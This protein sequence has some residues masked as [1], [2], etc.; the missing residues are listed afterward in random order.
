[1][2]NDLTTSAVILAGASGGLGQ[3]IGRALTARGARLTLIGRS[4]DR[5]QALDLAGPRV[6]GDLGDAETGPRA[7]AAT[8][9]EYGQLDGVVNAAGEV[10]FGSLA[11]TDDATLDRLVTSNLLGPLRLV[12][13]ALPHLDGGF[14]ANLSAVVAE[15]PPAG[16]AAYAATKAGLTAADTALRRELRRQRIDVIDVRPPHTETGLATRPIA[17]DPPDLPTG[18]DPVVVADRVVTAIE[19]GA[20]EV[21]AAAFAEDSGP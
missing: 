9:A 11:D 16:M 21:P 15:Q 20:R 7:V 10:A 1:V 6:V 12:R 13:A 14:V 8:L 18:L 3:A 5:L 19:E 4:E 17:G 2:G